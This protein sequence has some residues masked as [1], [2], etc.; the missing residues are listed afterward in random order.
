MPDVRVQFQ[1]TQQEPE[2]DDL[3][4]VMAY[5]HRVTGLDEAEI[6]IS[7][8]V[9]ED[10]KPLVKIASGGEV[11][12]IMLAVKL[13]TGSKHDT[14]TAVFDEVDTGVGGNTAVA[15]AERLKAVAANRQVLCVTHLGQVAAS[16]HVHFCVHK[17]RG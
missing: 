10:L 2:S 16:G 11:S 8:N 14:A 17:S 13:L 9:G 5:T 1:I 4:G 7:P 12:R 15:L 3:P 6:L